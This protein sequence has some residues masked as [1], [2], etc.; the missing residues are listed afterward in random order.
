MS[1]ELLVPPPPTSSVELSVSIATK[2]NGAAAMDVFDEYDTQLIPYPGSTKNLPVAVIVVK[3]A[4]FAGVM[5]VA[6]VGNVVVIAT[7]TRCKRMHK[8]TYYYLV[9]LAVSDL[10]V[11]MSCSWVYLVDDL[12]EGWVL[13]AF[14]C[15]FNSFVQGM[16]F[17]DLLVFFN[18]KAYRSYNI[19]PGSAYVFVFV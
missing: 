15:K 16:S 6:I 4:F 5:A 7:V 3:V 1:A 18:A 12:T 10:A 11:T 17:N 14:F 8:A 9:N 19:M 13:G 2:L